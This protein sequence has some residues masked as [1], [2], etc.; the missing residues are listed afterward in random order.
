[1]FI[2]RS[3]DLRHW[4][5]PEL[6]RVKG[7]EVAIAEM[8][9]MIDPYLLEDK[10]EPGKWWCFYKQ[11]GV[12]MSFSYD[13]KNWTYFGVTQSGENVC[14]LVDNNEYILFHSPKNG[15]AIKRSTDLKNWRDDN[16]LITLGQQHW[17]WAHGRITAAAVIDG[18]KIPA[19]GK[20]LMFYHGSGP[21]DERR[22][23]DNHASIAI[24]WSDDLVHWDWPR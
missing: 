20:Y 1:M 11:N 6:L 10:D 17:P 15:I 13:L 4:A 16:I 21:D 23:F 14:V 24:A 9:R 5:Q 22:M 18:R 12:S 19:I 2:M 3:N 8:G 7:P